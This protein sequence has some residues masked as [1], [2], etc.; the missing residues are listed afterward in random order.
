MRPATLLRRSLFHYWRTNLAVIGG[1]AVAVAVLA[2]ALMVGVSVR[3]SLRDLVLQRLGRTD[4][5]IVSSS[6][7][8]EQ[9]SA[10]FEQS[11]PLTMIEGFVTHQESGSRASRVQ[12]Y[13]IDE[14]FWRFHGVDVAALDTGEAML[15]EG[16]ASEL[17]ASAGQAVVLRVENASAI[18][19][20]SL[21]GRREDVGRSLRLTVREI[22]GREQL[23]EFSLSPRQGSVRAI[24]VPL[25][26]MQQLLEQPERANVVLIAGS[27]AAST[28]RRL[29]ETASIEDVGLTLRALDEPR[30]IA[31]ES[32]STILSEALAGAGVRAAE[33]L[34]M[35]VVP[36][37]TYLANSIR[38]G[39]R[40]IPYSV[41]TA[42]DLAVLG[43]N[44]PRAQ[45]LE[46]R[47]IVLNAWAA[48]DLHVVAGDRVSI[49]YYVWETEGRLATRR[50]EF[51]VAG[52]MPIADV[53]AD[54]DLVPEY[55]G[56]TDSD[57]L[58][59]WDPPFPI[60][61]KRVRPVD[62]DYWDRY[63]TT[64]KAF[65]PIERGQS[66]WSSRHGGLTA[67]RVVPRAGTS[68]AEGLE[69]YRTA[70]RAELDPMA[71][72]FSVYDVRAQSLAASAGATDFGEY[73]TYFSTFLVVSALLLAGLFFKLGVEQRLQEIGLLQALGLDP[74]AI[75]RLF[76]G[77]GVALS[78]IG[79][80]IGVACAVAYAWLIM[81]GLRTW[82]VDA[83]GT[84]ALRLQIDLAS[85]ISG[86]TAVVVI[87]VA[88]IWWSLR[89]LAFSSSRRLLTGLISSAPQI[90]G[91][92]PFICAVGF[93]LV[94]LALLGGTA[95][96][97]VGRVTGFFGAGALS[98]IAMLCAAGAWLRSGRHSI[99]RGHGM[100]AV[101][102]LGI[103]NATHRPARSV[104]C[105]AL[106]AFAT[107][108]IFAVEAFKREQG[109]ALLDRHSG[110]G[111]YPLLLDSLLPIVH[112]LNDAASRDAINLPATGVL[113]NVRFDRFRVRPGDDTSCLNLYQPKNPRILAATPEFVGS[114]R[115]AF[116]RSLAET[117]AERAN[118]WLLLNREFPD[119]AIPVIT[120]ANSMTYVLHMKLGED[121]I[122]PGS[123]Q[124]PVRL[125]LVAALA[126]SIFQ[127]ELLMAEGPFLRTFPE[128]EGYRFFLV[129]APRR[130]T[131]EL[132]ELLE[133]RL[134]DFGVDVASTEARLAGFHRV[135]Y[136]YLSTFQMLGG[137]GL[138]LGTFGLGAVLLRNVLER[139]RELALLR[140]L[141][142]RQSNFFVMVMAE[143]VVLLAGGLL[144]GASSAALA[145]A[146]M[147][148][149]RGGRLPGASLG[150][151][152][153]A[154]L[155]T[156][157][158]ASLGATAAALRSPLLSTLR[159]E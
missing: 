69:Q 108:V 75:R 49:E 153:L 21:H 97:F 113:Q 130:Q 156:G 51:T 80:V 3:A 65:I 147:F 140:A 23:G 33:S 106:I 111:G 158:L 157:F 24:F 133:S 122:L 39:D 139:R 136:T 28:E 77:E 52:V 105:I 17:G 144:V 123:S 146:P 78:A 134:S 79:A 48:K 32:R 41:I 34:G 131:G 127:G 90:K 13:A 66:L 63:R 91:S 150:W 109:D 94:A 148:L 98:M 99:L 1:V 58:A 159:H 59:D 70:L 114:G 87:A 36:T 117:S 27:D 73:F 42:I 151:L 81:L 16:L 121:L 138:V 128:W 40:E 44:G 102:R 89:S 2:G 95:L 85:L 61:L 30:V 64:P 25:R 9:L 10:S 107:F 104:L 88:S 60:D 137:L 67:L 101:W 18:P 38:A 76:V 103:R 86:A 55:P 68:L 6:F 4:H 12:V 132:T 50:A 8:R 15:S 120:D 62:E 46:P 92:D 14:R 112:D 31:L 72:G 22:L 19:T 57:R 119:D 100:W 56:I 84:T 142:Y 26:R 149:D 116:Q 135:E 74:P 145:I 35:V 20:E 126:D 124:R 82:W 45:S 129:D 7:F 5:A 93:G 152:L 54:R 110:G 141:G 83:V 115:F 37:L 125:R 143:N 155:L 53:A 154:V 47:A 43:L 71:L 118:P 29:R 11:V 96:G